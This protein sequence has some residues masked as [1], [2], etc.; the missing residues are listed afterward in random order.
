VFVI[1]LD[2]KEVVCFC[3]ESGCE[4]GGV[5]LCVCDVSGYEGG[6]LCQ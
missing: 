3:D 2:V 1:C 4:G 6:C 5:S